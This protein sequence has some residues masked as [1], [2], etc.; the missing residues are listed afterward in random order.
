MDVQLGY[1]STIC[2]IVFLVGVQ[3]T[4][5]GIGSLYIGPILREVQQRPLYLIRDTLN[6]EKDISYG[7]TRRVRQRV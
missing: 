7:D 4:I 1:T 6:F 5:T 3:L 2:V